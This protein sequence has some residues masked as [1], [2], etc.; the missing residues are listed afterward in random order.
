MFKRY[1]GG[2]AAYD[3]LSGERF[4]YRAGR[5]AGIRAL[6]L[7]WGDTVLDLGCGTGLN[8]P[9]LLELVGPG[10]LV[11]GVDLSPAML[12]VA[13]RRVASRGWQNVSLIEA[14]GTSIDPARITGLAAER[15]R[16]R[17]DAALSTYAMSVT[18]D[19]EAAWAVIRAAVRPGGRVG[20]VDMAVPVGAAAVFAPLA[21]L[22]C[23]TG[24]ADIH[25]APWRVIE[26]DASNVEHSVHRG[27]HIHVV[28]GTL[29]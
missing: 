8:L 26:R 19:H 7:A 28:T 10:G 18:G 24:G 4:V 15:G 13:R 16:D 27:G 11:I 17:V 12:R 6:G 21:R 23:A 2:A 25:A 29:P 1:T 14:D 20:I 9:L 22:A 5:V 3:V